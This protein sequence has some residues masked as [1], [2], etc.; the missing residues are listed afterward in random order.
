MVRSAHLQRQDG[1]GG[2]TPKQGDMGKKKRGGEGE[3]NANQ[4]CRQSRGPDGSR[5]LTRTVFETMVRRTPPARTGR[6]WRRKRGDM[7]RPVEEMN[8]DMKKCLMFSSRCSACSCWSVV[9]SITPEMKAPS[10]VDKPCDG[11]RYP[12]LM[13]SGPMMV[14]EQQQRVSQDR[15]P[16]ASLLLVMTMHEQ[17]KPL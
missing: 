4:A 8:R 12:S 7:M 10:S 13:C 1:V 11:H 9:D 6:C 14:Q 16:Y 2:A 17:V 5:R 15:G 3:D